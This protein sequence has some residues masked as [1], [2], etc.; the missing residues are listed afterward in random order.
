MKQ[1]IEQH[2]HN[3]TL[4]AAEGDAA[5]SNM[6]SPLKNNPPSS[7][8]RFLGRLE[9]T[10]SDP[11]PFEL[12]ESDVVWSSD[13]SDSGDVQSHSQPT[14]FNSPTSLP[15]QLYHHHQ[16]HPQQYGL[17]AALPD[18][19]RPLVRRKS[20]LNP[21][22]SAASAARMVPPLSPHR[23]EGS[24]GSA[25]AGRFPQSAPVN[26]PVWPKKVG[27]FGASNSGRFDDIDED[28]L[29]EEEE[30]EMVPPH[31]IVARSHVTTFSVFEGVGRTLKGRDLRCVRNAVF[32]K[33]G[34][35]D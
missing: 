10:D 19:H 6:A 2:P 25:V 7:T 34:F 16:F 35:I 17:S 21:S 5:Q 30:E 8:F 27:G 26:V 9:Q 15:Y 3:P 4:A 32:Q 31:E 20:T 24:N 29:E 28:D 13:L 11:N 23:S 18:D 33:T 1:K 14:A 22:L 12:D